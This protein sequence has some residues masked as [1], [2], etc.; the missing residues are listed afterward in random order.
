MMEGFAYSEGVL[1]D[2]MYFE[3]AELKTSFLDVASAMVPL[4]IEP[5]YAF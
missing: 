4:F 2:Y 1:K 3:D 5:V